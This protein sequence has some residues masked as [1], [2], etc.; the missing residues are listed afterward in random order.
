M[1]AKGWTTAKNGNGS[2]PKVIVVETFF[3]SEEWKNS[4]HVRYGTFSFMLPSNITIEPC[5]MFY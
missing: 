2:D 3:C 4:S 1:G 5:I